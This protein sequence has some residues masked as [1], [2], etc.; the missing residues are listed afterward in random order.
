MPEPVELAVVSGMSSDG[1]ELGFM[2]G[3]RELRWAYV[4]GVCSNARPVPNGCARWARG[5]WWVFEDSED[6]RLR[7][8]SPLDEG[9]EWSNEGDS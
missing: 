4:V 6:A 8:A 2:G 5:D 7:T 3:E 1:G 9:D